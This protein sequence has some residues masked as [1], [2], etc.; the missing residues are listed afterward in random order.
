MP[1]AEPAPRAKVGG[2]MIFVTSGECLAAHS[3]AI[4]YVGVQGYFWMSRP[5]VLALVR[6]PSLHGYHACTVCWVKGSLPGNCRQQLCKTFFPLV[7]VFLFGPISGIRFWGLVLWY[8]R[9]GRAKNPGPAPRHFAV[10]VFN[11][12]CWLTLGDLALETHV[13]FLAV[14]EHRLI[15]ARVR[16]EWAR[17]RSKGLASI[18]A[19]ASQDSSHLGND[20]V[21]AIRLRGAPVAVPTFATAQF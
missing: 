16:S 10:D 3:T 8:L 11:V 1:L 7:G 13:D 9:I 15:L 19:P 5:Y 21:G 4:K 14:V 20:G 12:G 17:L 6:Q 18:W 2:G